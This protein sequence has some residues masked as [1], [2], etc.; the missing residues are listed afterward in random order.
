MNYSCN[1]LNK[2]K[3]PPSIPIDGGKIILLFNK[4]LASTIAS[5]VMETSDSNI[6]AKCY[7]NDEVYQKICKKEVRNYQLLRNK[8]NIGEF[9][10]YTYCAEYRLHIILLRRYEKLDRIIKDRLH[11][12]H[13]DIAFV[14]KVCAGM[15]SAVE[16]Y[17]SV[18]LIHND[19]QPSNFMYDTKNDQIVLID[20]GMS[21]N[22][23]FMNKQTNFQGNIY[24][25]SVES[26]KRN[27]SRSIVDDLES[28]FYC[29]V[30]MFSGTNLPWEKETN[31]RTIKTLKRT[32]PLEEL[33]SQVVDITM[34]R[35]L[36][37][38]AHYLKHKI[39]TKRNIRLSEVKAILNTKDKVLNCY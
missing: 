12:E 31:I 34:Q 10:K 22:C 18:N 3:L 36:Q 24:Y 19:I 5:V 28:I 2:F 17:A 21:Y 14:N 11:G 23:S 1:I 7:L 16:S 9:I 39:Y 32:I 33:F 26:Q 38:F 30:T 20:F 6:V 29:F 35:K 37:K 25:C 8:P 27:T 13:F 15:I 4:V